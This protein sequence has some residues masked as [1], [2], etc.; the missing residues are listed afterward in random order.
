MLGIITL[1]AVIASVTAKFAPIL[2]RS[3]FEITQSVWPTG[4]RVK[5]GLTVDGLGTLLPLPLRVT[6]FSWFN[7]GYSSQM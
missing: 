1:F 3:L 2:F 6:G 5:I 7:R 4:N